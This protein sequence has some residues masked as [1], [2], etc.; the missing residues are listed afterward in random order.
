LDTIHFQR[1]GFSFGETPLGEFHDQEDAEWIVIR[2]LLWGHNDTL[3]GWP[4]PGRP[5]GHP[6]IGHPK[7]IF[8]FLVS[9]N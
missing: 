3:F 7:G 6:G 1:F 5:I 2:R 9:I 4:T 8:V